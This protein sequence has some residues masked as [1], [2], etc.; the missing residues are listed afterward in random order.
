[1]G[2]LQQRHVD[3]F[4]RD[5]Y[6]TIGCGRGEQRDSKAKMQDRNEANPGG[7]SA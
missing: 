5:H 1:M 3:R 2:S 6:R 4:F 7:F